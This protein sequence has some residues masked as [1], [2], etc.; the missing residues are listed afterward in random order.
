MVVVR[1]FLLLETPLAAQGQNVVLDGQLEVLAVHAGKL[2]FDDDLVLVLVYVNVRRPGA[3]RYP[4]VAER[5]RET[6][7]EEPVNLVL[8]SFQIAAWAVTCDAHISTS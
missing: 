7:R 2:G 5:G 6:G 4:L 1:L 8:Q 3:A